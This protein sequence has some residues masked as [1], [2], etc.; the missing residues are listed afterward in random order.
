MHYAISFTTNKFDLSKEDENPIN[1][2]HGQSLILWLRDKARGKVEIGEPDTEDWGWY[3]FIDWNGRSYLLGAS[4]EESD[5]PEVYW[6]LQ[7]DKQR[8]IKEKLLGREKMLENDGCFQYF[9]SLLESEPDFHDVT[10]A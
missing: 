8:T 7:L 3:T 4:A 9:K 1:P 6:V 10:P 5:E 2:I